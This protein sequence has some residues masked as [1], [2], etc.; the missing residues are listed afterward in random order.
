MSYLV[1][2]DKITYT[3]VLNSADKISGNN[4]NATFSINWDTFLPRKYSTYKMIF[5]FATVG[6]NFKDGTYSSVQTVFS[7]GK[8]T[9]NLFTRSYQYESSINGN[10]NTLGLI[11]RDIQT[12]SS[13]SNTLSCFY[14]QNCSK[15]INRPNQNV[16]TVS[17]YNNYLTNTLLVDTNSG[18]TALLTDMPAWTMMIGFIPIESSEIKTQ[19]Y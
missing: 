14:Y 2:T 7:S 16:F 12:T 8:I 4:N 17:V 13:S 18:G 19:V 11:Q 3:L 6:G 1:S 10:S 9:S 15:T 5:N